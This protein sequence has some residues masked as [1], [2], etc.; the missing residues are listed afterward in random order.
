MVMLCSRDIERVTY[1]KEKQQ[2]SNRLSVRVHY[3]LGLDTSVPYLI[4]HRVLVLC[5]AFSPGGGSVP[6][7]LNRTQ[8]ALYHYCDCAVCSGHAMEPDPFCPAASGGSE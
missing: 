2:K 4:F 5:R 7:R 1:M 6:G 3:L 8:P